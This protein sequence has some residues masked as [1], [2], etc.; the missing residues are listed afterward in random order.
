MKE[1]LV[2]EMAEAR[3]RIDEQMEAALEVAKEA[4]D[5]QDS[6]EEYV[7]AGESRLIQQ[8]SADDMDKLRGCSMP[9]SVSA[10]SWNFLIGV[11]VLTG[12]RS[13]SVKRRVMR[14]MGD[15]RCHYR[16]VC[17]GYTASRRAGC[18]WTHAWPTNG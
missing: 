8:A 1:L 6:Q 17:S 15:Y 4:M 16:T 3:A 11:L 18:D 9:L 13:S 2:T 14:C 12:F 5:V 10:T 7:V